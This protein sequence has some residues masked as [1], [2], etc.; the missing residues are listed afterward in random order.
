MRFTKVYLAIF[1]ASKYSD[2]NV[3]INGAGAL[4]AEELKF[5][6][7]HTSNNQSEFCFI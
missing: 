4:K 6:T 7:V 1:V 5:T 2:I 3:V